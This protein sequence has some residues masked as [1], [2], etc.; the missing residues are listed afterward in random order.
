MAQPTS[1]KDSGRRAPAYLVAVRY[2]TPPVAGI[3]PGAWTLIETHAED[4]RARDGARLIASF[5]ESGGG[6][7]AVVEE[8]EAPDARPRLV[9][10]YGDKA[11]A[12]SL[13][14]VERTAPAVRDAFAA[15]M[16]EYWSAILAR[17]PKE[18]GRGP[19][20]KAVRPRA[21]PR[22]RIRLLAGGGLAAALALALA[23]GLARVLA[24]D[25][26]LSTASVPPG[27]ELE[28]QRAGG[29]MLMRPSDA[30]ER[31]HDG[32]LLYRA[33]RMHPDGRREYVG[34]RLADGS[35]P[36]PPP[37]VGSPGQ[38]GGVNHL[39]AI[40]ESFGGGRR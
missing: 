4:W 6:A 15:A 11:L 37:Q 8:P 2:E 24:P 30:E 17:R 22:S 19:K 16:T 10:I 12:E 34:L 14:A 38:R 21:K 1:Q 5:V 26:P 29:F 25:P 20:G 32:Q 36:P 18:R 3:A 23:L 28:F 7:V 33:Y 13:A 27:P 9:E 39:R 31:A 35:E 40:S